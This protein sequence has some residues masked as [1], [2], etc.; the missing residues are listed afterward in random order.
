M[1]IV[2]MLQQVNETYYYSDS[3]RVENPIST[4][5]LLTYQYMFYLSS[6]LH[7]HSSKSTLAY[8]LMSLDLHFK[9]QVQGA[10]AH[11][12]LHGMVSNYPCDAHNGGALITDGTLVSILTPKAAP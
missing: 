6:S 10:M 5:R 7:A 3:R 9:A 12:V 11:A 2:L 4:T 8:G 1:V